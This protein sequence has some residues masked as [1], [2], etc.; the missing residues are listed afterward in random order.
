MDYPFKIHIISCQGHSRPNTGSAFQSQRVCLIFNLI[1]CAYDKQSYCATV[2]INMVQRGD[3]IK[4]FSLEM[5]REVGGPDAKQ[6][7]WH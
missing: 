6:K 3:S 4:A 5:N 2:K 7:H 1:S